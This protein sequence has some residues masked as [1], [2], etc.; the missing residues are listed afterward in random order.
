MLDFFKLKKQS[1][2]SF[3]Q[4]TPITEAGYVVIDTELTGLNHRKDAIISIGAVR[5]LGMRIELGNAFH[6]LVKP[7]ADFKPESVVIHGITPSDVREAEHIGTILAEFIDF[8][9]NDIVIGHCVSIDT[10][11]INRDMKRNFGRTMQ[12]PVI[13]TFQIYEWL[14]QKHSNAPCFSSSPKG[15]ALYEIAHCFGIPIRGAHDAII[16]A[17]ITAQLFQRFVPLLGESGVL[18]VGELCSLG[19]PEGGDFYK[20]SSHIA[21]F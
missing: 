4:A 17:F 7:E 18:S 16:D 19:N 21:N 20:K 5:M 8:C 10:S 12:N 6:R 14:K 3:N 2:V 11:F 1:P 13:D 15:A 9:G